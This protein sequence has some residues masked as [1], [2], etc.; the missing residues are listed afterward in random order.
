MNL[1][2]KKI[3]KILVSE[4][5]NSRSDNTIVSIQFTCNG[6]ML[7]VWMIMTNDMIAV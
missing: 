1:M 7:K 6:L 4:K 5:N 3:N 2:D